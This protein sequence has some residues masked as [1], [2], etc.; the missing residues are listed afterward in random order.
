MAALTPTTEWSGLRVLVTG[1]SG[2]IGRAACALLVQA[3]AEVWGQVHTR[4]APPG[5]WALAAD[6]RAPGAARELVAASR[7]DRVLHL[8]AQPDPRRDPALLPGQRALCVGVAQELGAVC[9]ASGLPLVAAGSCE[10]YGAAPTPTPEDAP[11]RP[12][13]PYGQAKLEA[14]R[15][16]LA[17]GERG[18]QVVVARPF[19]TY[20]AGQRGRGLVAGALDA[21]LARRPFPMTHGAQLREFNHADDVAEGLLRCF[22]GGLWGQV[23]NLGGAEVQ[24]IAQ[25]ARRIFAACGADPAL[26]RPGEAPERPDEVQAVVGDHR[27]ARAALGWAPRV[28]LEEGI[29]RVLA[30]GR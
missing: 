5:V 23:V 12:V 20:G 21:A 30:A 29:A 22:G 11:T 18:V 24:P 4:P 25:A 8:A 7:P 9:A 28:G 10:E 26:V 6:L 17:W 27:R 3:G 2:V 14:T 19:L 15:A 16:L 1:A 13:T